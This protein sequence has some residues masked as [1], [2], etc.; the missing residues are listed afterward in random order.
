[1]STMR[2]SGRA[3]AAALVLAMFVPAPGRAAVVE[4]QAGVRVD[5]WHCPAPGRAPA[6]S[7]PPAEAAEFA[8]PDPDGLPLPGE[9]EGEPDAGLPPDAGDQSAALPDGPPA[10]SGRRS[11]ALW[12]DSHG[13]ARFLSDALVEALGFSESQVRPAFVPASIGLP[14]V[15][16]PL[17]RTCLGKGWLWQHA[18]QSQPPRVPLGKGLITM[19][20]EQAGAFFWLDLGVGEPAAE[21][22]AITLVFS[23]ETASERAVVAVSLDDGP[24]RVI[25]LDEHEDGLVELRPD[26]P[27]RVVKLRLLAGRLALEGFR[28]R[29]VDPGRVTLDTFGIPGAR[30]RSWKS[31]DPVRV[32]AGGPDERYDLVLLEYGTNEGNDQAFDPAAYEADLRA[33]LRVFREAYPAAACVLVGPTD[34]GVLVPRRARNRAR[35][36]SARPPAVDLLRYARIHQSI[37]RVQQRVAADHGCRFWNWQDA[38]GGPGGAYRWFHARPGLMAPDLI[39]LTAPGYRESGRRLAAFIS[40]QYPLMASQP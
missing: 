29:Y 28:P 17:R 4:I 37:S 15:R 30:M 2:M 8:P 34:R 31:A 6:K 14:G 20:S 18:N 13:A 12:G 27:V 22:E 25:A 11:I 1:M 26:R 36:S 40:R 32:R 16:L 10:A 21:L 33:G 3:G 24:E 7:R 9:T 19:T 5:A 23:P 39:H 35:K 38:M